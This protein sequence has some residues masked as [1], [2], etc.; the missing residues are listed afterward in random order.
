M[1]ATVRPSEPMNV[2]E[3]HE[4]RHGTVVAGVKWKNPVGTASG[5]FQLDACGDYYDVTQMGAICTKGVSPVPWE[6]NPGPRIAESPAGMV[7]SVGLQN[8][9]VD[10]YLADE[11]PKLKELGALVITNVAGHSDEDYA[12]VTAKLADSDAD[13]L[14]IN[15][16]CP[17]VS[18]GGMSVGTDPATLSRLIGR[19]RKMT[20][21]PM[22][23]KLSPNVTDI[24][25]IAH[26]AVDAGA[27]AL[28]LINTL[29]GMRIDI[30]TGKPIMANRTGG[31][32]GPAVLPIGLG[33]VWRV[34][35]AIPDIPIIG[36]GGID[37]GEKALEYLYAG[38]NAV[39]VGAAAL[40]DPTAPMR[41]ARELDDLLDSRPDL[42]AKL[43]QGKSW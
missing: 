43:A 2:I 18:H 30:D 40:T 29:V 41:V 22:I 20:D 33:F 9:G 19:L 21:K 23:V 8:P 31:V 6:G 36:I 34:R 13:M 37:S 16:S 28:S 38:A 32:S 24:V 25:T 11:L 10:H 12:E 15:V 17:N 4:W 1:T 14:E 5:T 7:N 26:A 27:D 39:E 42:A 35:Q 3:P